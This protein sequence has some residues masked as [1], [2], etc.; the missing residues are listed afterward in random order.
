MHDRREWDEARV[1]V[2][3]AKCDLVQASIGEVA[4]PLSRAL[5][6]LSPP[7]IGDQTHAKPLRFCQAHP[8]NQCAPGQGRFTSENTESPNPAAAASKIA[9][10]TSSTSK[11]VLE[12]GLL[13]V[14]QLSQ[15][16]LHC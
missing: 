10:S 14:P 11:R 13:K 3:S 9:F 7:A 5:S 4:G 16:A 2:P 12:T 15:A 8:A 1:L 6:G